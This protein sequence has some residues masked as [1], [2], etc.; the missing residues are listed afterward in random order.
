MT[1][2][3]RSFIKT[4]TGAAIAGVAAGGIIPATSNN[5]WAQ[6]S[7]ALG[8]KKIDVLS[9]G[10]LSLPVSML[11][12]GA[13]KDEIK[14]FFEKHKL[15]MDTLEPSCNLT[16]VRDGERTILF[17]AGSGTNFMPSAGKVSEA[18]EAIELDPS[19][20]THVIF[21]HAHPDHLWGLLDD[22]DDPLFSEAEYMISKQEWDYWINPQTVNDISEA[23]QS[24]AVGAKR[25][26]EA[27]EDQITR[28]DYEAE[29]LPGIRA[30]NTAGHTPG[31]ASFE[32][33][34]GS[35]SVVVV[36][37]VLTNQFYSFE[38]P[39]W[40][41]GSDQDQEMGIKA[42]Q[43]L[44]DQMHTDKMALIGFHIP[45]P[46]IGRVEKV[47]NEYRFVAG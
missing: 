5:A 36:G 4:T 41:S 10:N 21:T 34:S 16:L 9:D 25:N 35:E 2:T 31:H 19:E 6:S 20:V 18:L 26:L 47:D 22:F 32:I 15:A 24:F 7:M 42:R 13:P 14:P 39:H 45:Y 43:S 46:G 44:L 12:A 8:E 27:I 23:R 30:I 17:D 3:R 11:M 29:I 33:R 1:I 28:F 40:P 37:D 38:K